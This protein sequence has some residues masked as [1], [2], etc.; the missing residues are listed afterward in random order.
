MATASIAPAPPRRWPTAALVEV[1]GKRATRSPKTCASVR[2]SAESLCGVPVP[3]ALTKSIAAASRPASARA[4]TIARATRRRRV[5]RGHVVGVA[6]GAQAGELGQDPR[7]PPPACARVSSTSTAP[8]SPIDSPSRS[9][10]KGRQGRWSTERRE[11]N[12]A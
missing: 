10:R 2:A 7:A 8:P 6:G 11:L 4:A 5:G 3:W 9:A 1:T 12:P